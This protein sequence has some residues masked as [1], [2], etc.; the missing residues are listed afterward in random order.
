MAGK[1]SVTVQVA[2]GVYYLPETLVF[3]AA[4]AGS[5][6][7]PVVYKSANEG[8]AVLSGGSKLDLK[9]T[10]YRDGIFQATTPKG[11]KIDQFFVN[12]INQRMARYPNHDPEKKAQP[13][14]GYAADAVSKERAA[15]WAD[16]TGG[17]IHAMHRSRWGGFHYQITG[18]DAEGEVTY[19]SLIH[20]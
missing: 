14:Q 10:P 6:E 2:D 8:G 9:W 12:G 5:Q 4:D 16:P 11:L 20:I 3:S 15:N 19:L 7:H 18:K 1:K 17:Y 13:Y